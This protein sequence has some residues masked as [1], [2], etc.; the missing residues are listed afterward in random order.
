MPRR[1]LKIWK[2]PLFIVGTF[3]LQACPVASPLIIQPDDI[4]PSKNSADISIMVGKVKQMR[5]GDEK[6][7]IKELGPEGKLNALILKSGQIRG[8]PYF[9]QDIS[10]GLVKHIDVRM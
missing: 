10:V 6:L 7:G 3:L 9:M 5:E 4:I 1:Q 2:F 8:N